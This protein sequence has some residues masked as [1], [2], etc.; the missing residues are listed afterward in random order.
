M[1]CLSTDPLT[2]PLLGLD[3]AKNSVQAELR[4]TCNTLRFGFANN[5]KGF[6][7]LA[8]IL[9]AHKAPKV[10]AGLEASGAYSHA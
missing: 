9:S 4:V 8:R 5:P 10:W 2:L 7:Q 6:A 3:V 1:N